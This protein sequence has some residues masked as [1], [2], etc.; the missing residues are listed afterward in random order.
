MKAKHEVAGAAKR[1]SR[2]GWRTGRW[3]IL[4]QSLTGK[5]LE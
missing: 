5:A 1:V 3:K 2:I 4:I